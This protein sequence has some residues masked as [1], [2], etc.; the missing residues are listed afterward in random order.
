MTPDIKVIINEFG[1]IKNTEITFAPMMIFTGNS[2][3]GKSYVNYLIYYFVSSFT[4]GRLVKLISNKIIAEQKEQSFSITEDDIRMWLN[5]STEEF[6]RDFLGDNSLTCSANYVFS[7]KESIQ[8]DKITIQ[9]AERQP[10]NQSS[11][12]TSVDKFLTDIPILSVSVNNEIIRFL[13]Y[14]SKERVITNILSKYLQRHIFGKEISKSV[15]LPPAR[16]S[17]VGE[18]FSF[19]EKVATSAGMYRIFLRDYDQGLT[20]NWTNKDEQFFNARIE[21]LTGGELITDKGTQYLVLPTGHK[22]PLSAAASSIKELSP[23]FFYL[24]NWG[25][26][27]LSICI[28]EPEAHLHPSM[29]TAIADLLVACLN[30][31]M[32]VQLTTHSDYFLQRINQ[33]L[34][35]GYIRQS[36]RNH[37]DK[38]AHEQHLN[39]RHYLNAENIKAYYFHLNEENEVKVE[40]LNITE[41]G[42]PLSSFFQTVKDLAEQDD[43][44]ENELENLSTN[45]ND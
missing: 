30:K 3:L 32:F 44:L 8:S 34:K 39:S 40:S 20:P 11:P 24:K 19:K 2:N 42:I 16:G 21:K 33:L 27:N 1:P 41:Q 14:S 7:I 5:D 38:I 25:T 37:F 36:D 9:Y 22:L 12:K 26:S 18:N 6:M 10:D 13:S 45:G 28:E 31:N 29:Q 15:I 23:L 35:L 17:F 4:E 43:Y